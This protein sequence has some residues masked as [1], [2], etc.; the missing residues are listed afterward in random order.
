M[1]PKSNLRED[2]TVFVM[3]RVGGPSGM[4]LR[5]YLEM[6]PRANKA[7]IQEH[8]KYIISEIGGKNTSHGNL[9][10]ENIIVSVSPTGR[11]NGMW[12][13]DFGRAFYRKPGETERNAFVKKPF[14]EMFNTK[15]AF[16]LNWRQVPVREGSRANVHMMN[17]VYGKRLSPSWE[18]NMARRRKQ[19][20][21][22]MKQ[23]RSPKK[24]TSP[25][26]TKSL[27]PRKSP[28]RKTASP[29]PRSAPGRVSV[30]RSR[31]LKSAPRRR[32][33]RIAKRKRA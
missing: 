29:R 12:V 7:K 20:V 9:H 16:A 32:S 26:R 14:G 13:I 23:Y 18:R 17:A 10:D 1:F 15:S 4:S 28:S 11:I 19:V 8:I 27:S 21:E 25:R 31:T 33:V 5:K 3:S 24:T 2:L 22:E 6:Y 30:T